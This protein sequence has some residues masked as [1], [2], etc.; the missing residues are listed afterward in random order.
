M[1]NQR[2]LTWFKGKSKTG[3]WHVLTTITTY[4]GRDTFTVL[5]ASCGVSVSVHVDV[6]LESTNPPSGERRCPRCVAIAHIV[7]TGWPAEEIVE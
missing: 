3:Y 7:Q 5:R 2:E 4:V 6:A 1:H